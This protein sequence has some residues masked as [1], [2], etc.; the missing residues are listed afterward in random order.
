V[1]ASLP[2]EKLPVSSRSA[3]NLKF[4]PRT[5]TRRTDTLLDSFVFAAWRPISYLQRGHSR[6]GVCGV[7]QPRS[8]DGAIEQMQRPRPHGP[9]LSRLS[10]D[11]SQVGDS[12]AAFL[13]LAASTSV[14][15]GS[16]GM[17]P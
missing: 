16:K 5:R 8:A 13:P 12:A 9:D 17:P 11:L 3:R 14:L 10:Y 7:M 4:P 1:T 6:S 2:H 15:S